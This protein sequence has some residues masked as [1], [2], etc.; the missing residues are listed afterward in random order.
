MP[1]SDSYF[2]RSLVNLTQRTRHKAVGIGTDVF[3]IG[4]WLCGPGLRG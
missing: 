2:P 4:R 3:L 1:W